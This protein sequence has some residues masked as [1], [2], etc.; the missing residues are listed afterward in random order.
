MNPTATLFPRQFQ[1][2]EQQNETNVG[3]THT[4]AFKHS[5]ASTSFGAPIASLSTLGSEYQYL[6]TNKIYIPLELCL[7]LQH[8]KSRVALVP[9]YDLTCASLF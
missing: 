5:T 8:S 6:S 1:R 7:D 4:M 3:D 2:S 9:L